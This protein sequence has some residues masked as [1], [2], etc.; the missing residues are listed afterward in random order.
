MKIKPPSRANLLRSR[1]RK[2][3]YHSWLLP[4]KP[5]KTGRLG[6]LNKQNRRIPSE[7]IKMA[8]ALDSKEGS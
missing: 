7:F 5:K 8:I 3:A 1:K 4:D 2:L 6:Q